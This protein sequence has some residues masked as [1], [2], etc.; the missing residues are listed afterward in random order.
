MN[1]P[2]Y[3][4]QNPGGK[5][6]ILVRLIPTTQTCPPSVTGEGIV[7]FPGLEVFNLPVK[8]FRGLSCESTGYFSR[9]YPVWK[10]IISQFWYEE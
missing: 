7:I 8:I 3:L 2:Q 4:Y 1:F 9:N 10:R 6:I 5:T